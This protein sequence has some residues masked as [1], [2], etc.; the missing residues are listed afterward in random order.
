[1]ALNSPTDLSDLSTSR[2]ELFDSD[3]SIQLFES[4]KEPPDINCDEDIP[5]VVPSPQINWQRSSYI[6]N[7]FEKKIKGERHAKRKSIWTTIERIANLD[8]GTYTEVAHFA[9]N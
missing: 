6:D 8:I 5:L 4:D 1:M 7:L 3:Q 9:Q 2:R